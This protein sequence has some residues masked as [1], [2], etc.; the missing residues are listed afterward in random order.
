[1]ARPGGVIAFITSRYTLDKKSPKVRRHLAAHAEL[2]A[3]ARLPRN[4]FR[5]NAGTEVITD[6]LIL[7]KRDQP[8]RDTCAEWVET[9][10][11][12]LTNDAGGERGITVNGFYVGHPELMLGA[13]CFGRGMH[14]TD[15]F[16]LM[17]DGRDLGTSLTETLTRQL[18]AGGYRARAVHPES[19]A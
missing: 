12:H 9:G 10:V 7:R 4:A 18:P 13:P 11:A 16:I 6:V 5:A 2:L 17:E 8:F 14:E 19:E 1:L 15:E 3:A